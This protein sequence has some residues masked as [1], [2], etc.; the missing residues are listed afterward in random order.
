MSDFVGGAIAH[1]SYPPV[2][3][4]P[5]TPL[6]SPELPGDFPRDIPVVK[7]RYR[8]DQPQHDGRHTLAVGG[9][10]PSALALASRQLLA[11]GFEHQTI[12]GQDAYLNGT[13]VVILVGDQFGGTFTLRYTVIRVDR[14]PGMPA[15]PSFT[16]PPLI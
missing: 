6:G 16:I 13:Y 15:M 11:A 2:T 4:I 9:L 10:D 14:M 5:P 7:G 8:Q 12:A 3:P 1:T